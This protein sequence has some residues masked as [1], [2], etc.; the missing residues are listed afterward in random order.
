M[1]QHN[2]IVTLAHS[3]L[4]FCGLSGSGGWF[5]REWKPLGSTLAMPHRAHLPAK[6]MR[7]RLEPA[8][9][10]LGQHAH[11]HGLGLH[12]TA[13]G[14]LDFFAIEQ[15]EGFNLSADQAAE[16]AERAPIVQRALE[17]VGRWQR[18]RGPGLVAVRH[19]VGGVFVGCRRTGAERIGPRIGRRPPTR[20][21]P[22]SAAEGK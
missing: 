7:P 13:G 14:A 9:G 20:V 8:R 6:W 19:V 10:L 4:R 22:G 15:D 11:A 1:T 18:R 16:D 3:R 5:A 21:R 12:A 2:S 17:G